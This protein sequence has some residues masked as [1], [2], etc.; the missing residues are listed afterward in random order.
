M[1]M[2]EEG[3]FRTPVERAL[4]LLVAACPERSEAE[5]AEATIGERDTRLLGLRED[6]FGSQLE[7]V[8]ECP[9][10]AERLELSFTTSDVYAP[11]PSP[12]ALQVSAAGYEIRFRLPN[13]ADLTAIAGHSDQRSALL[14]RCIAAV[15]QKGQ[16][17]SPAELPREAAN[18]VVER[19]AEA[20]PQADV[21]VA[22]TCSACAHSW[23]MPFD[24]VSYLW[25][26][27][28]DQACRVV[29]EVHTLASAYG[30]SEESILGMTPWRRRMYLERVEA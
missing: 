22:L 13:S 10:C 28:E 9:S 2:W 20:D 17:V 29:A 5:W 14:E 26:E 4:L 7:A 8:A 15:T 25:G 30:W 3:L 12:A 23:S 1:T 19:M 27:I 24:I 16:G 6:L 21:L 11:S 18:A